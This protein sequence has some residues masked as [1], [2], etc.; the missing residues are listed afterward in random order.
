MAE[1]R[2]LVVTSSGRRPLPHTQTGAAGQGS[3]ALPAAR[4]ILVADLHFSPVESFFRAEQSAYSGEE[5]SASVLRRASGVR[6]PPGGVF[7]PAD[8]TTGAASLSTPP[9]SIPRA[10][11][12]HFSL[13]RA[14]M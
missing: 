10:I 12:A 1:G 5:M 8:T 3:P 7:I 9:C 2:L 14:S 11:D 4:C 6:I 13:L